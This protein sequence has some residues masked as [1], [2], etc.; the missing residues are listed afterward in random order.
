MP[1]L[2]D[3]LFADAFPV[4]GNAWRWWTGELAAL[5]PKRV[6]W[7]V[8]GTPRAEIRPN[9]EGVEIVRVAGGQGEKLTEAV[10]LS[11]FTDEN[12]QEIATLLDGHRTRVL[13]TTPLAHI[14][15]LRLPKA[16]RPYLRTAIP[17]QLAEHAPLPLDQLVWATVDSKLFRESLLIRVAMAR[18]DVLDAIETGFREYHIPLPPIQAET[19]DGKVVPLRRAE[20]GRIDLSRPWAWAIGILALTPFLVLLTL[21]MLVLHERGKVDDLEELARPKLA[22]ERRIREQAE[23]A[24]GLNRVLAVPAVTS[25]IEGL[26]DHLPPSAHALEVSVGTDGVLDISLAT[27]DADAAR[28]A[29]IGDTRLVGVRQVN[30][31]QAPDG[32]STIQFEARAR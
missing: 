11:G 12:W 17:L 27:K 3:R 10:P 5:V 32:S 14:V 6:H 18:A 20:R 23:I 30:V 8:K 31:T 13:L 9:R 21:H 29:L 4:L 15:T 25:I 16:A 22:A 7:H 26:A 2:S 1:A 24:R 28:T 19:S